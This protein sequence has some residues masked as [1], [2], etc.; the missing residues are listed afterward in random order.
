MQSSQHGRAQAAR[1]TNLMREDRLDLIFSALGD[2][3]RRALLARLAGQPAMITELAEPFAMS[4]PAVSR[5]I[6][7]L[8]GA[9]LV[10]R[11]VDGRVHQCTLEA[12]PLKSVEAWLDHYRRFWDDNLEALANFIE[13][14]NKARTRGKTRR[15]QG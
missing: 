1:G 6:R 8:E 9:G 15:R 11:A 13:A 7:V 4:L 2:R 12:G 10:R 5:H 14:G 3:T